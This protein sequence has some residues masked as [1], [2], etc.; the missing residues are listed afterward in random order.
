M[1]TVWTAHL[2]DP[3]Q[4]AKLKKDLEKA[5]FALDILSKIVYNIRESRSSVVQTDYDS[6][7]WSHKQAHKNGAIEVCDLLLDLLEDNG[8][9]NE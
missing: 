7:S 2:K 6:P 9:K 4:R 8:K 3:E 1:K 5:R